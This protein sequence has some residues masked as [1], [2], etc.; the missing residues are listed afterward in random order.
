MQNLTFRQK[1]PKLSYFRPKPTSDPGGLV[2]LKGALAKN[3]YILVGFP[4]S[5]IFHESNLDKTDKAEP[6]GPQYPKRVLPENSFYIIYLSYSGVFDLVVKIVTCWY[7][8]TY[9]LSS[10]NWKFKLTCWYNNTYVLSAANW[11][12]KLTC[13][14]C[15]KP[16]LHSGPR[17]P[18]KRRTDILVLHLLFGS[19]PRIAAGRNCK[20]FKNV[21]W[22][23]RNFGRHG[24]TGL[25]PGAI[26]NNW[27]LA[28]CCHVPTVI[29]VDRSGSGEQPERNWRQIH[30]L[31]VCNHQ[32][33][34]PR[35]PCVHGFL[36]CGLRWLWYQ[37]R[38][39][40][41]TSPWGACRLAE[42]DLSVPDQTP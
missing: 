7:N 34:Y 25:L 1:S 39:C 23:D 29:H 31:W 9:V 41:P 14:E 22:S 40:D 30:E 24:D 38:R 26:W 4:K 6:P 20:F 21:E 11:K 32:P 3:S 16:M 35:S 12:F 15:S 5:E 18:F 37:G 28:L 33:S 13:L 42:T 17:S 19:R 8:D 2:A 27:S 10:A 36:L